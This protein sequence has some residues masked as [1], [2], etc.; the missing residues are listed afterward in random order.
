MEYI[1]KFNVGETYNHMSWQATNCLTCIRK[2]H[3]RN[4]NWEKLLMLGNPS[5]LP[6]VMHLWHQEA[7]VSRLAQSHC[8]TL[9]N[10]TIWT[11]VLTALIW[12]HTYQLRK[13]FAIHMERWDS[14]YICRQMNWAIPKTQ[15]NY[16]EMWLLKHPAHLWQIIMAEGTNSNICNHCKKPAWWRC[17]SC[18][19]QPMFCRACCRASHH[20]LMYHKIEKWDGRFFQD[21]WLWQVG[22]RLNL[23][24]QG[25]E[26]PSQSDLLDA[27]KVN[28]ENRDHQ[29]QLSVAQYNFR[30]VPSG[31]EEPQSSPIFILDLHVPDPEQPVEADNQDDSNWQDVP[32]SS[33]T[34]VPL[35][36]IPQHLT[37][38]T[39]YS[40]SS[41]IPL[42]CHPSQLFLVP[43]QLL[44]Q[45]MSF[46]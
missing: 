21:A 23:G 10:K 40:Y 13:R 16:M 18:L 28:E 34:W 37:I 26:C 41:L 4:K 35:Q 9:G 32:S 39:I 3:T 17:W 5:R 31:C 29:D 43:A 8:N 22:V 36:T 38:L 44:M 24:H 33:F 7:P 11:P 14:K 30:L 19:S 12:I 25:L 20:S 27:C 2:E 46:S 42:D 45:L 1:I 6:P 15:N